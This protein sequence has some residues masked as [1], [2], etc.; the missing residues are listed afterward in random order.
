MH[1]SIPNKD[2][3]IMNSVYYISEVLLRHKE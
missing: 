1:Y 3:I 2:V